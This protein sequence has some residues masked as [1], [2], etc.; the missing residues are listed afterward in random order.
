MDIYAV[1]GLLAI[2]VML[3]LG[4]EIITCLGLGAVLLVLTQKQF[5]LDNI[6]IAAFSEINVFPLLA[7]PLYILTGDLIAHG[8]LAQRLIDFSRALIGWVRGGMAVTLIVS[9]GLFSAISGSNAAT[10][11]ALGRMMLGPMEK[12]GYPKDFAAAV[13]ACGGTT[14][15]IIPPSITFVIYGVAS[16]TSI[17][18][19]FLAGTLP[20][21]L[22]V[23]AMGI[24]ASI[25]C[26]RENIGTRVPFRWRE[27]GRSALRAN[28]AFGAMIVILGGIYGGIFTA[29]EAAAVAVAYCFLVGVFI[30][31]EI[32]IRDL[33]RITKDS[34]D[35]VGLIAP[36]IALAVA[37]SQI[38]SVLGIPKAGV[39]FMLGLS[40]DPNVILLL[41]LVV[42]L[43]AGMFME[44]TPIL[45][46]F[47]PM[48]VPIAAA[49]QINPIHFGVI[50]N[51]ALAIGFVTPP[52]GL[53]LFVASALAGVSVTRIAYRSWW[54]IVALLISLLITTYVPWLS[55]VLV[56]TM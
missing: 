49:L 3:G 41:I 44:T 1:L 16:G 6:G 23:V 45:I 43:I 4:V 21:I 53:N 37:L 47:T 29:T 52:I 32:K 42:L 5:T 2:I 25:Q 33:P 26:R 19:L 8:G 15:I 28:L 30:T 40:S 27:V 51:V 39:D 54:M 46:L 55:L 11:A 17:G 35:V 12:D 14:G 48:L 9:A 31:R 38:L 56:P 10:V 34:A 13:A 22:M 36:I 50:V 7:M 18:A 24:A 20:G